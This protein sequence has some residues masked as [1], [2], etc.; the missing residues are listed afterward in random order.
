MNNLLKISSIILLVFILG[1]SCERGTEVSKSKSLSIAFYNVENLFDTIDDPNISDEKYT[2][3]SE[4]NWNLEKYSHKLN[5][6]SKVISSIDTLNG[7]PAIIGLC[8]VENLNTVKDLVANSLLKKAN[9]K[10][11]HK[12]SPDERGIDVTMLYQREYYT[13][14]ENSF[15]Y[16]NL[17]DSGNTTRDILYSKGILAGTDTVHIFFNHWVSR[18]GGQEKTEPLR[19]FIAK[20]LKHTT[21]SIMQQNPNAL[22]IMAGDLNDNPTDKS[23]IDFLAA[24]KPEKS[25]NNGELYNLAL[26][27]YENGEG[28]IYYKGW[29]MF[30]QIIVSSPLLNKENKVHLTA[31]SQNVVKY[32]WMLFTPKNGE[33]RPNRTA[34]KNY[35]GGFSDHLPVMIYLNVKE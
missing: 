1:N 15:I 24:H 20:M 28:S 29:S 27:K 3:E 12:D 11:I 10:I 6:L 5:Q 32:D 14:L 16:V 17:P 21:D 2:P 8:E 23:V 9:Y 13:P 30:D 35:Y 7:F 31:N 18:W 34:A 26:S 4:F 25:V 22:I 33:A 19:I